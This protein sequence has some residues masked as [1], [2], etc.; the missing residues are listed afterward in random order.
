MKTRLQMLFVALVICFVPFI[1][2]SQSTMEFQ[3]G[4]TIEVQSG[5]DICADNVIISG[6]YTGSGTKC[7][8]VLPVE[9]VAL[10]A[11]PTRSAV[12]LNWTTA[13][14]TNDFGF[15][16]ERQPMG[17]SRPQSTSW[18]SVGLVQG[19]GTSTSPTKYSFTDEHISPGRYSYRIKQIDKNGS[20]TYTDATDVEV[21]L[22]P[23]EFTLSQNY[24]NPFNPTT[25]IEF[26]LQ[27]DGHVMLKLYD[28]TGRE[29][30]TLLDEDR[31]AGYYQ[32]VMVDA[33]RFGS[34][35]YVY[36][37]EAGGKVLSRKMLL[38]K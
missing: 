15:E 24:P 1:A 29:V 35:M 31:K 25:T 6:S 19:K 10:T 21:G 14:E 26:T 13:T 23:K 28:V 17:D 27:L 18:A 33:A 4:T 32:S 22:A 34:G 38:V 2:Q 9:L 30:A 20:F 8:G 12:T 3:S 11:K 36:R 5:A 37:L 16:I 7:G